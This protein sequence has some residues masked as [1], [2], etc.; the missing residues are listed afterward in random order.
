MAHMG[1]T[2]DETN[3]KVYLMKKSLIA[4]VIVA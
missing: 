4:H 2:M 3:L 1:M